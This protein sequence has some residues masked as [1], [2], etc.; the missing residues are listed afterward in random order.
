V[1]ARPR[2][3]TY[4]AELILA[5]G[6]LDAL[7]IVVGWRSDASGAVF[8]GERSLRRA[9]SLRGSGAGGRNVDSKNVTCFSTSR[10]DAGQ[11]HHGM[12]NC[13]QRLA[14]LFTRI[15]SGSSARHLT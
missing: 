6:Y 7:D 4:L 3:G 14:N 8:P 1:K 13:A 12:D 11:P 15:R 2:K 9:M 10:G 5:K